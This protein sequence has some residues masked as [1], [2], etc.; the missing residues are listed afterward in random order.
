MYVEAG[1][2]IAHRD[3]AYHSLCCGLYSVENDGYTNTYFSE[4]GYAWTT[5]SFGDFHY[6]YIKAIAAIPEWAGNRNY[7]LKSTSTIKEVSY[8][9]TSAVVY[10]T[11][12]ESG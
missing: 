1:G 5:D 9:D 6:H 2:N 3:A 10:S 4:G 7:L 12:D 11:F 8:I